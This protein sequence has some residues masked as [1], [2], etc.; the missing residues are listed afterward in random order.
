MKKIKGLFAAFLILTAVIQTLNFIVSASA[1]DTVLYSDINSDYACYNAVSNLKE[2]NIVNGYDNGTYK[3][4]NYVTRAEF[5]KMVVAMQ[6]K[7]T[8]AK[9]TSSTSSFDDVN[10]VEWSIPYVN[11]LTSTDVI[12]GYADATFKPNN[13]ITY[14][15]AATIL[16]RLL[17]YDEE[18]IGY[19]WPANYINEAKA[20]NLAGD[21]EFSSSDPITRSAMAIIADNTLFSFVNGKTEVTFLESIGY[22]VTKD[23]YILATKNEDTSLKSD[24]IRTSSGKYTSLSEN[25]FNMVGR[26]GTT[27]LNKDNKLV[28]FVPAGNGSVFENITSKEDYLSLEA[29]GY[30]VIENCFISATKNE[31]SSLNTYQIRTSSGVYE[32]ENTDILNKVRKMGTLVLNT[33]NRAIMFNEENLASMDIV[34]TK[35]LG[36]GSIEYK[37]NNVK[38]TFTFNNNFVVYYDNNKSTYQSVSSQ[39]NA[40]TSMTLYGETENNWSF[41]LI[42]DE[43]KNIVPVR[44]TKNYTGSETTLEGI[45]INYDDLTVY[46]EDK[47]ATVADIELNDVI[48]Y[49]T[50]TNIMDVYNKKISGIYNEALPSK[51]YVTSVN[52]GGNIYTI[53]ENV[54]TSSLDASNG[55]FAIGDRITLLLG[56]NDEVCFAV[57]LSDHNSFDYGV[58]LKTYKETSASGENEGSTQRMASIFMSDG[59]TYEYKINKDY[60]NMIGDLVFIKSNNGVLE[61]S[62]VTSS[63]A[64]GELN[65]TS[66]T[67]GGKTVL[68]DAVV[69]H[70]LSEEDSSNVQ[71]EILDFGRL[72]AVSVSQSQLITS[73]SANDF[74]DISVLYL[75]D[76]S[77][78][79]SYGILK[80]IKSMGNETSQTQYTIYSDS[81]SSDYMSESRYSISAGPVA[82]KLSS[83]SGF[84]SDM[85]ALY[86]VVNGKIE[87]VEGGRIKIGD[88]IYKTDDNVFI[89]NISN[90]SDYQ[91]MSVNELSN[92]M[93]NAYATLYVDKKSSEESTVRVITVKY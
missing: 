48:Y 60:E 47:T 17:G 62:S 68:K 35:L 71:V 20:L 65:I 76:M 46:K 66:R 42:D 77:S 56:E 1:E 44:A 54:S 21:M 24:E 30:T 73:V 36:N 58:L 15:E 74:G 16:C 3:P 59:N 61:L 93:K 53:N 39:I 84:V 41:A 8:E 49:N 4:W 83:Q 29:L 81:N 19:N 43:A 25:A 67:L 50:K 72:D 40:G 80:N 91:V 87:A 23:S 33:Q 69:F 34:V 89:V 86:S 11:Y 70:R 18:T 85:K 55:S 10:K 32:V 31:E 64:Y 75:K 26:K 14:A 12:K 57:E 13:V 7:V 63:N 82:Y 92:N 9:S 27:V 37:H 88:K 38:D 22:T 6:N 28:L 51:S 5:C 52:V 78:G 45:T 90:I 79:Y 2:L